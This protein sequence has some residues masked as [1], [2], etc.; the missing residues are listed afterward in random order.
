MEV[1]A[2]KLDVRDRGRRDS[3]GKV[4]REQDER[5]ITRVLRVAKPWDMPNFEGRFA[6]GIKDL[7]GVLN[8]RLA[9]GIDEFL[10]TGMSVVSRTPGGLRTHL[11]EHLPKDP[12]SLLL[13]DRGEDNSDAIGRGLHINRLLVSVVYLHQFTLR[14][15]RLQLL[16]GLESTLKWC[17][18][19]MALE[20]RYR[21]HERL[22]SICP[23]RDHETAIY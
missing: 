1:V 21:C 22:P 17:G 5:H 14:P 11:Q 18:V 15:T 13:E 7:G 8:R 12:V 10:L 6:G 3:W 4:A 23:F 2:E 19:G 9:P 16:L 20:E